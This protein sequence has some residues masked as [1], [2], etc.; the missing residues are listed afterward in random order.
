MTS[1][2]PS[3][4][5]VASC[6]LPAKPADLLNH[7]V[8]LRT[9]FGFASPRSRR[10]SLSQHAEP[11][12]TA[13]CPDMSLTVLATKRLFARV[14]VVIAAGHR[15]G[16]PNHVH[17]VPFSLLANEVYCSLLD[18]RKGHL[19]LTGTMISIATAAHMNSNSA[20]QHISSDM[21]LNRKKIAVDRRMPANGKVRAPR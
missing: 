14:K 21:L 6:P 13:A 10:P 4:A 9:C 3:S 5:S 11:L 20:W 15:H 7:L 17:H 12:A 18:S 1:S 8:R 2:M 19:V 16:F